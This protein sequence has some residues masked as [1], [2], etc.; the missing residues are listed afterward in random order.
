MRLNLF[1]S[2]FKSDENEE[3][4]IAT[5]DGQIY[6]INCTGDI[7]CFDL[8]EPI[9]GFHIGLYSSEIF[10]SSSMSLVDPAAAYEVDL[11][12]PSA[13][14]LALDTPPISCPNSNANIDDT[15][16]QNSSL[17]VVFISSITNRISLLQT[18]SILPYSKIKPSS[19]QFRYRCENVFTNVKRFNPKLAQ[20]LDFTSN[21]SNASLMNELVNKILYP[22]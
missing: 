21:R 2:Y 4:M 5:I 12:Q 1:F 14:E 18:D 3:L 19:T 22:N 6:S 7:I 16:T 17:C 20:A 15:N 13:F 8:G 9:R 11:Y 10:N